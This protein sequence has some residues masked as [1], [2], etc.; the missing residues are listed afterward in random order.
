VNPVRFLGKP[1]STNWRSMSSWQAGAL[2]ACGLVLEIPLRFWVRPDMSDLV[3]GN[4]WFHPWLRLAIEAGMVAAFL[5]LPVALRVPF[6]AAGIPRRRWTRW[7]WTALLI[8]GGTELIVVAALVGSRW[9]RLAESGAV[10]LAMPWV[11]GEFLFGMNQETGFRGFI[12]TGLLRLRGA[13][14]A[15]ILNTLLFLFGPLHGPG[16]G[17]WLASSPGAAV[18]YAC[19][20]VVHG[21]AYSWVRHRTDNVV[22]CAILHGIINGFMNGPG[23]ALRAA[24]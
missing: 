17:E 4:P 5:V 24:G 12:M 19:G 2:L 6:G 16:I 10:G 22:L 18:G 23:L 21:V 1:I 14:S 7:E 11:V 9:V 3:P 20:V 15:Y 8:I 13:P